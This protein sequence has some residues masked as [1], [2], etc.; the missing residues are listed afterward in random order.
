MSSYYSNNR[1]LRHNQRNDT[2][3]HLRQEVQDMP[4]I[5]ELRKRLRALA[6]LATLT[7]WEKGFA[8]SLTEQ[9]TKKGRLSPKQVAMLD[10]IEEKNSAGAQA[11]R[12]AWLDSWDEEKQ[13]T[14]RICAEYYLKTGYFTDAAHKILAHYPPADGRGCL[15]PAGA[16]EPYIPSEKL[17]RKMC[18]NKY[19]Q[20][21]LAAHRDAPVFP[22]GSLVAFRTSAPWKLRQASL[23][24]QALVI[25]VNAKAPTSA[26]KGAKIYEVL[27]VGAQKPVFAEERWLKRAPK[28]KKVKK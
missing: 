22:V 2:P 28:P 4:P 8:E 27:P 6:A 21:V 17:Y 10:K 9:A 26:A 14:A 19:A 23:V 25:R 1:Y 5:E 3:Q 13:E 20:R 11:Q 24:H 12:Q 18:E 16:K 7:D 15:P